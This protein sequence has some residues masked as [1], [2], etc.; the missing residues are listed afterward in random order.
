MKEDK[1]KEKSGVG[2]ICRIEA[3]SHFQASDVGKW[4]LSFFLKH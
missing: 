2:Q 4:A 1:E 3:G